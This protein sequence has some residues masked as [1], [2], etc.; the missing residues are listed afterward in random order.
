MK[1]FWRRWTYEVPLA[2]GDALWEV[3]VVQ[4]A[5][6]LDRLTVRK[7]IA[8]IPVIILI[9]AYYHSIP[10]PPELMLIGDFLAYIDIFSVLFLLGVLSRIT[11]IMFVVKQ[12]A[13]RIAVLA[14]SVTARM[15][16]LDI[17]HGRQRSTPTR[18]RRKP[19][20]SED[21]RAYGSVW[22]EVAFA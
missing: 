21:D 5:A 19:S 3:L 13:A 12:A 4:L 11:T 9:A 2:I 15:Q 14:G 20:A 6:L 7:A 10:I 18:P 8:F 22:G 16:R 1:Q 17:R